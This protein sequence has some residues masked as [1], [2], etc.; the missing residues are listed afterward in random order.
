MRFSGLP[1]MCKKCRTPS[2]R[3][4]VWKIVVVSLKKEIEQQ[5]LLFIY[6]FQEE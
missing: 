2:A 3:K 4:M 6:F 1:K 5:I